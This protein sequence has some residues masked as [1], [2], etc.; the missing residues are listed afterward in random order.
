MSNFVQK[1]FLQSRL[2]LVCSKRFRGK[3]N[4]QRPRQPHYDRARVLDLVKP[5]YKK[6]DL[7]APCLEE[8]RADVKEQN[9]N[10]YEQIIAREIRNWLNHSKMIAFVHLNSI[11]QED[12]F[13][14]QVA[15]HRHQM[16]IKVY[17]KSVIRQAVDDTKYEAI[18]SLFDTKTALV[19]CPDESKI[20]QLLNIFKKT[21]QF[22]LLA[23]I[24][25][26]QFLSKNEFVN[27]GSLP[28]LTTTRA[29]LAAV[30]DSAGSKIVS[31]L[32]CHQ[33]QLVSML[34]LHVLPGTDSGTSKNDS[35]N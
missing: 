32:Q 23:G 5:I 22:I 18:S 12:F 3:I 21:P 33:N 27:Y 16:S 2:P 9:K 19:F 29:Q 6:P 34:D 4:I 17:T 7:I 24:I 14:V 10:P 26:G 1:V 13:K 20:R 35:N 31:D 11:K 25:H 28:D 30:L 8:S 15:L